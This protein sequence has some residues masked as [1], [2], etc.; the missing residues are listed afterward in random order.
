MVVKDL[1]S[2]RALHTLPN[3]DVL[4][5]QS[6]GPDVEPVLGQVPC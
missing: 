1:V 2:P 3:G 4:V 5:V 6:R